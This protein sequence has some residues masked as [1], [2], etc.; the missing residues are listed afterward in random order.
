[1]KHLLKYLS[2]LSLVFFLGCEQIIPIDLPEHEPEIVVNCKFTPD[3]VWQARVTR[4]QSIQV[5]EPPIAIPYATVLILENGTVMDTLKYAYDDVFLSA[6]GHKPV[7]GHAYT[8]KA[9]AP[10]Y[11]DVVGSDMAPA[12][13]VPTDVAW[14][15]SVSVD[16]WGAWFAEI[17]FTIDDPADANNFYNLNVY[18]L[19]TIIEFNDTTISVYQIYV[20]IQDPLL[21]F[22]A[23][24]GST[25]FDDATFNGSRRVIKVQVDQPNRDYGGAIFIGLSTVSEPY[26]R[27]TQTLSSYSETAFNPFA[28]PVR[29]YSNM[30]PGMGIFAGFS[31]AFAIVP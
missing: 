18:K 5:L 1:M 8:I 15:D 19:D 6:S 30:T 26:Y 2:L 13:V 16:Q 28:E 7:A 10:G 12:A 29:I 4:S 17:S 31:T 25:L 14:R 27:Y 24:T 23:N 20:Q 22:D 21:E 9:S 3:S 11:T